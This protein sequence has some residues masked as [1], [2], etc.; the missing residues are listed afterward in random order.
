MECHLALSRNRPEVGS[1]G[2]DAGAATE[3]TAY[4]FAVP[5]FPFTDPDTGAALSSVTVVTLPAAGTLAFDG[6]AV[7]ESQSVS[8]AD[9]NGADYTTFTFRVPEGHRVP[10]WHR[11]LDKYDGGVIMPMAL[12]VVRDRVR[13]IGEKNLSSP[14]Q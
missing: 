8:A 3:D 4:A 1:V 12:C 10:C 13:I 7:T 9:A 6:T 14:G 2:V 11:P 5:E